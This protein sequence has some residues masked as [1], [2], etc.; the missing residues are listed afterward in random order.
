[1]IISHPI[2]STIYPRTL[3]MCPTWIILYPTALIS[4]QQ[5][6]TLTFIWTL[7]ISASY[8]CIWLRTPQ[9]MPPPIHHTPQNI[10]VS[11]DTQA[12][13]RNKTNQQAPINKE[14]KK[15]KAQN[16]C[17]P[18]ATFDHS[19]ETLQTQTTISM[20]TQLKQ[21]AMQP[22]GKNL[23]KSFWSINSSPTSITPNKPSP[24]LLTKQ[25]MTSRP[26]INN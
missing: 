22:S 11:Y 8:P 15:C 26:S 5:M 19:M 12:T 2:F 6:P 17:T 20:V 7:F 10:M 4:I 21:E 13:I 14:P 23:P 24:V 16:S 18:S 9:H 25:T 3:T 1:M